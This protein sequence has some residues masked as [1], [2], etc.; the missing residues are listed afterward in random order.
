MSKSNLDDQKRTHEILGAPTTGR[1]ETILKLGTGR[2]LLAVGIVLLGS[3]LGK[4]SAAHA[5]PAEPLAVLTPEVLQ[6]PVCIFVRSRQCPQS[7]RTQNPAC[8]FRYDYHGPDGRFH[9]ISGDEMFQMLPRSAPV[10]IL[11]HGSFVDFEEEPELLQTCEW[12]RSAAPDQ[13][14][15]VLC[16]RWPSDIGWKAILGSIAVCQL[17]H[18]A[19]FNGFY[20][21]QLINRVPPGNS[22][23]LLGHSHGCR[24]IAAALHLL[25]GGRVKGKSLPPCDWSERCLRVTFFSAAMDHDW[26][27]P[28]ERYDLAINRMCWLQN[29]R[30][31]CDWALLTYPGRYP[32]SACALGKTGF[33]RKDLK[34]LGWQATKIEQITGQGKLNWGHFLSSYL[35][36]RAIKPRVLSNIYS[37]CCCP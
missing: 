10:L 12:I 3:L 6:H 15:L 19:E 26:L 34:R 29:H 5:N 25:S 13:P 2:F 27:N 28:G 37:P 24:M 1:S 30:H 23:S 33:T 31:T 14:L 7:P 18:R 35:K 21:S 32:G 11:V 36:D 4:T 17:A 16:Y 8:D 20:L 9:A 22:V